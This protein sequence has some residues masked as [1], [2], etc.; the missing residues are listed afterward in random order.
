MANSSPVVI[1]SDQSAVPITDNSGSITV[2]GTVTANAGT[3]LN[4]S[5]LALESGG[6]LQDTK[7][8]TKNVSDATYTLGSSSAGGRGVLAMGHDGT[9]VRILRTD[10]GGYAI[11]GANSG[12]DVGDVT[13]NNASG[14]SAVNIQDGGNSITIDGTVT[15]NAGTGQ[16]DVEG[17]VAHD[18]ANS[19]NP[20]GLG[21]VA[22]TSITGITNVIN[23][24]R[25]QL[26]SDISGRLII[27]PYV[28]PENMV[29]AHLVI[30]NSS[31]STSLLAGSATAGVRN[32][33]T[34]LTATNTNTTTAV[35][36]DFKDGTTN[37]VSF[38]LAAGG[39]GATLSMPVPLRLTANTALNAQL[40]NATTTV[41]LSAQGFQLK[42]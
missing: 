18:A 37:V 3:D 27:S 35:R 41:Y 16:F 24:D 7:N 11:L 39:G 2:D 4:T 28:G 10:T 13:I 31:V 14:A 20:I 42:N 38:F 29:N 1:A 8:N 21:G 22:T 5:A 34:S 15:A 33:I 26:Y 19:G 9:Q 23:N 6:N 32:Y 17:N 25:T 12:V 40:S 36:V 30:T